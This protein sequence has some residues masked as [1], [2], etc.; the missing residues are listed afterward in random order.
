MYNYS[1]DNK[2]NNV[3]LQCV[4]KNITLIVSLFVDNALKID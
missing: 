2:T 1:Q 4:W 3:Q